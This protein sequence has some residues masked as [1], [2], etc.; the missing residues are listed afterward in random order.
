VGAIA[1][2]VIKLLTELLG[3]EP[4]REKSFP[5]VLGDTSPKTGRAR[6]LPF[7]A[8]WESRRLIVEVDEDQHRRPVAFWDKPNVITVSGVSRGEQRGIYDERKRA[9]ARA[10]GY[11]VLEIPWERRPVPAK[12]DRGADLEVLRDRFTAAGVLE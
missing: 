8:V 6:Q 5:W 3:E 2:H 1:D 7:D 12:R 4:E 9:A 10:Q 11:T